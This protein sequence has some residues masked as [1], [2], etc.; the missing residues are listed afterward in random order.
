MKEVDQVAD[1]GIRHNQLSLCSLLSGVHQ[2]G[3]FD[4]EADD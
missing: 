3:S 4:G 1:C 2:I